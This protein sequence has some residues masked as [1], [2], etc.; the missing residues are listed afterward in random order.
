MRILGIIAAAALV[1]S[2]PSIA[3]AG[4]LKLRWDACWG[5]GGV[6]NKA[7][8]CDVNTGTNLLVAS[9]IPSLAVHSVE[10]IESRI[11]L[12]FAGGSVP[13]WW[14]FHAALTC[15]Q[16]SLTMVPQA[17]AS[18]I[19]C[20]DWAGVA[21]IGAIAD[22]TM[23]GPFGAASIQIV[24]YLPPPILA[25]FDPGQEY[26]L[27]SLSINHL[28]TVGPTACAGCNLGVCLGLQ[29]VELSSPPPGGVVTFDA[30][31]FDTDWLA[32]WQGGALSGTSCSFSTA[33]H[34]STWGSVKA[35]YR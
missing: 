15:R 9:L 2:L 3:A 25:D 17:P 12:R 8:A 32:T 4:T 21:A 23:G 6:A 35:L 11:D 28:K 5:D 24:S 16:N 10:D 18:S 13:A 1:L 26:F 34:T 29:Y 14:Q 22:Y 20:V 27:Y 30:F 33:A 19:A 31:S 7:F